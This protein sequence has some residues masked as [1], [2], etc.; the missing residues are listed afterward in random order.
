M[1]T[2]WGGMPWCAL[3][4]ALAGRI[5]H[6]HAAVRVDALRRGLDLYHHGLGG[7][8]S[9]R[10]VGDAGPRSGRLQAALSAGVH[11]LMAWLDAEQVHLPRAIN[12]YPTEALNRELYYWLAAFL[13]EERPLAGASSFSPGVAHLLSGCATSAR[14]LH[15]FPPLA[16]R[17]ARLCAAELA[18]RRRVLPRFDETSAHPARQ[19]EAAIRHALGAVTP[20]IDPWFAAAIAAARAGVPIPRRG[21]KRG[22][23]VLPFL[24]VALWG[25]PASDVSG[26]LL[27]A[28]FKRRA[29]RSAQGR[30]Q[31][32]ARAGEAP[33]VAALPAHA[34]AAHG[35]FTY[36][37]WHHA[38]RAYR[39]HWCRVDEHPVG[40]SPRGVALD[41]ESARMAVAVRLR[42]EALR[43][44]PGWQH[45][46]DSGDELDIDA[47]VR[48]VCDRHAGF[49]LASDRIWQ[50]R[51]RRWRDLSVAVLMDVSRSTAAWLGEQR[52]IGTARR[53]MLVL[54]EA[55]SAARDEFGLFA[56]H[57]DSRLRVDCHRIKDFDEA[58]G[59]PARER[60]AAL[61]P[62]HYTRLGA[63]IRH[64]GARLELRPHAERL[65]LVLTDGRPHDPTDGYEGLHAM[66][67]TRRA[68]IELRAR[69]M[70]AFALAID[71]S[72]GARLPHLFGS[73]HYAVL[74]EPRALP[75]ALSRVFAR[76]TD[77]AP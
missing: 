59:D 7:M 12:R 47:A 52:V 2:G 30:E 5:R 38:A 43:Q 72:A 15:A 16:E 25:R 64:V 34:P 9:R 73:G 77:H 8:L 65:L 3:Q 58:W 40:T 35:T 53:A 11:D 75:Q 61:Q 36:P 41:A 68:L 55:L 14:V 69:G 19:L 54:A 49:G 70:Q 21:D 23:A 1:G 45:H 22:P 37:E 48:A 26:A 50:R 31:K 39:A 20:P 29:R 56:F 18:E 27:L 74:A 63:A 17:H 24:P 76:I 10:V 51:S 33:P 32:L 6:P 28:L 4:I 42:F 66:E 71:R 46:L 62:A 57:S 13:A 44:L 60:L 67:D